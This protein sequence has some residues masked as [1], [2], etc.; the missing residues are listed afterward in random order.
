MNWKFTL[1]NRAEVAT[2]IQEPIGWDKIQIGLNRHAERHGV[3]FDYS[4]NNFEFLGTAYLLIEEEYDQYGIDGVMTLG[5]AWACD[6]QEDEELYRGRLLFKDRKNIVG[7]IC[8]VLIP[9]ETTSDVMELQNKWDQI[10]DLHTLKGFDQVTDLV[11]Y[12][13]LPKSIL[14]PSKSIRL[15]LAGKMQGIAVASGNYVTEPTWGINTTPNE[16]R[17]TI[18]LGFPDNNPLDINSNFLPSEP[19]FSGAGANNKPPADM[20]PLIELINPFGLACSSGDFSFS[21]RI[22]GSLAQTYPGSGT[23]PTFNGR[24]YLIKLPAGLD[25]TNPGNYI[26]IFNSGNIAAGSGNHT[27]TFDYSNTL[28]FTLNEGDQLWFNMFGQVIAPGAVSTFVLTLDPE[29]FVSTYTDSLCEPSLA[30]LFMVHEALSR[31]AEAIT[32][33]KL[34]VYSEYFGRTDSEPFSYAAD[35]EGS[36]ESISKGLYLRQIE[37]RV[38]TQPAVM[39]VSMKSLWEGLNPIHNIG[40][41]IEPDPTRAGKQRVRFEPWKYFYNDSLIMSCTDIDQISVETNEKDIFSTFSIGYSKWEAEAYNGLDEI[42][43][44]RN[45]RTTI[46]SLKNDFPQLSSLIASGYAIEI[47]RRQGQTSKDWRYD[48]DQFIICLKRSG[49]DLVVD[50]GNAISTANIYDPSTLYN[51]RISPVRNAMR[52]LSKVLS[53]YRRLNAD[54]KIIFMD[55][56]GNYYAEGELQYTFAKLEDNVL[57]ETEELSTANFAVAADGEP[58]L[59][60]ERLSFTYPVSVKEFKQIK[61]NPHGQV[62]FSTKGLSGFGWIDT[63]VHTPYEGK[64]SFKL[65]PKFIL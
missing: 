49:A 42:M 59:G 8:S 24:V 10:V 60:N 52:W 43:T 55:G 15:S 36:L 16:M 46:N 48:N 61:A 35:G 7:D 54:S 5:I 2:V 4:K 13:F 21:C 1:Y 53:S 18:Q 65:I 28:T 31:T 63:M 57:K 22:K 58:W 3:L 33:D 44:K 17:Y 41:G 11:P 40:M 6:G 45:Y 32:N 39:G 62:F 38:P 23:V 37:N 12:T 56:E 34:R 50:L 64:A 20:I 25:P 19:L 9:V 14:L 47:T 26:T 29:S 30:K 51:Y 27:S